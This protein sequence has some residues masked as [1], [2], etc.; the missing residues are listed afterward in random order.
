MSL[1]KPVNGKVNPL[2]LVIAAAFIIIIVMIVISVDNPVLRQKN[3]AMTEDRTQENLSVQKSVNHAV[4]IKKELLGESRAKEFTADSEETSFNLD[5]TK[6]NLSLKFK[7]NQAESLS[8]EDFY[9]E[10]LSFKEKNNLLD[11]DRSPN[12]NYSDTEAKEPD[13]LNRQSIKT[14]DSYLN[15]K[16]YKK[17]LE[18]KSAPSRVAITTYDSAINSA[19]DSKDR[20]IASDNISSRTDRLKTGTLSDYRSFENRDFILDED[21]I[22]PQTP[23][24]LMQGSSIP[25]VLITG[26]NS[27]LPGQVTAQVTRDIRDSISSKYLLIPRGTKIVGQYASNAR[28]GANRVFLGFNR[29][30]FP[31]GSSLYLGAMPGQSNDGYSGLD[32][33]VDNHYFKNLIGAFL[34]SSVR[35][36]GS[37][38][39]DSSEYKNSMRE[40]LS[41]T[42]SV[43]AQNNINLSP[44]LKVK[45]GFSFSIA[46]TKD[47][48]FKS[49]YGESSQSFYIN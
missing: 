11:L 23:Y 14:D 20:T 16:R 19:S 28:F 2:P 44:V 40:D 29:L 46:V 42:A 22:E 26:I 35:A 24:A 39:D 49:P 31:D 30:I 37:Y 15:E 27:E 48:F 18:A 41:D 25:A 1:K 7:N 8:D 47:I 43:M 38:R 21:V 13:T 12:R 4:L 17:Y 45:A 3:S 10:Y 36:S 32:A 33:D 5:T 6:E 9:K 34:L